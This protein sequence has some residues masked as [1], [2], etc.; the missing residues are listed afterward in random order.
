MTIRILEKLIQV[1][2]TLVLVAFMKLNIS[3]IDF[4]GTI[5]DNRILKETT[6]SDLKVSET[7][8]VKVSKS[9]RLT[10]VTDF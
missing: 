7:L 8:P 5:I 4:T 6:F 10:E 1:G 2:V 9:E 3:N